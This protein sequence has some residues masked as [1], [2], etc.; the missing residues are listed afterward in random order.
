[1]LNVSLFFSP[2]LYLF[3][4][5][6]SKQYILKYYYNLQQLFSLHFFITLKKQFNILTS[7]LQCHIILQK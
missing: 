3:D 5:K 2:R 6:Y 7:S 1:M 4:Q